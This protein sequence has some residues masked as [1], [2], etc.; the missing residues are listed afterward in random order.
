[1]KPIE[2]SQIGR[3]APVRAD[4]AHTAGTKATTPPPPAAAKDEA[5]VARSGET[6]AGKSAPVDHDR[7]SDIRNALRSGN[8]P[9]LPAKVADAMIAA[10]F[11]LTDA[12]KD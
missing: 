9:L 11:I 7:I 1:M 8:Y 6:Q 3:T 5:M 10:R 12:K 2:I 4:L